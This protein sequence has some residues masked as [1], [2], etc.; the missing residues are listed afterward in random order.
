M[1]CPIPDAL[2]AQVKHGLDKVHQSQTA[3]FVEAYSDY[4]KVLKQTREL[5]VRSSQLEKEAA[6]LRE[7]NS[8][9]NHR[10]EKL[11]ENLVHINA[12]QKLER[13]VTTLYKDKS[14]LLEELVAANTDVTQSKRLAHSSS[15]QLAQS[16]GLAHSSSA[17]LAQVTSENE[18]MKTELQTTRAALEKEKQLHDAASSELHSSMVT[19]EEAVSEA[20]RLRAENHALTRRLVEIKEK[21]VQ[22]MEEIN[23]LH[24]E[25]FE[26]T[27]MIRTQ[28]AADKEANEMIRSRMEETGEGH[29]T[30][31]G[32]M[33][34]GSLPGQ[35]QEKKLPKAPARSMVAHKGGCCSLSS[36]PRG[37]LVASCGM[38]RT[39][40]L[41]DLGTGICSNVS[42]RQL[43][44][45]MGASNDVAF[46]CEG[47]Q[48]LAAGSDKSLHLWDV[49][50][51]HSSSVTAVAASP[52]D[53]RLAVSCAE[54]RCLK[55]WDL[56][57]GFSLR[58]IPCTKMPNSLMMSRDGN[59]ILSDGSVILWDVRQC[60][61]GST[62]SLMEAKNHTQ[63][64][65]SLSPSNSDS[66]VVTACKDNT[67]TLWDFRTMSTIG[68]I[69]SVGRGHCHV[70]MSKDGHYLAVGATDG[71]VFVWDVEAPNSHP[72]ILSSGHKDA[73]VAT[74]WNE[75]S[76]MLVTG[77]KS[78]T[79]AF[80]SLLEG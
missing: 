63:P 59:T 70:E 50:T 75:D 17:Q 18:T 80:W 49:S 7:E 22:R 13:E 16:K 4:L 39:V 61:G 46:T 19:R 33:R 31:R 71:S 44:G 55:L 21:E 36:Q 41:W 30:L 9:L 73:V 8:T 52:L 60:R 68:T 76:T 77:D 56:G 12:T 40:Q 54:D 69:G 15:A 35:F 42:S 20:E 58:S 1:Q 5:K 27:V 25:A 78:G 66:L 57:R 2:F 67:L 34:L 23:Q 24:E 45:M 32:A 38:D 79:I 3:P 65:V 74:A 43:T 11:D 29:V 51:G 6:E 26:Q 37:Y 47:S 28:A 10:L 62:S 72:T 48:L 53:D 64:I 14:R